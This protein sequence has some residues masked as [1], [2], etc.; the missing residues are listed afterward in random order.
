MPP[1]TYEEALQRLRTLGL[2]AEILR[3]LLTYD[4]TTGIFQWRVRAGP[5]AAGSI[6]GSKSDD[7]YWVIGIGGKVYKAHRL[8]YLYMT[9]E[10]PSG[11]VDHR[12]I[13]HADNRWDN[14]RPANTSNN[15]ANNP[16][17]RGRR[18]AL[19]KGV[20]RASRSNRRRFIAQIRVRGENIYL[21]SFQTAEDA[22]AA[23]SAAANQHFGEFANVGS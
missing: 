4:P 6:A 8:A 20:Y 13:D 19:P 14:L 7:G 15:K 2:T 1:A 3:D 11:Q 16:G 21:G 22:H 17:Y 23:Y 10:W 12:N 9:G 18:H 5:R